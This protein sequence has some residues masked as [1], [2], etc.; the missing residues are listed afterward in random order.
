[1]SWI[2]TTVA[3]G[4]CSTLSS[5]GVTE[6]RCDTFSGTWAETG[7]IKVLTQ[8]TTPAFDS[9]NTYTDGDLTTFSDAVYERVTPE[10]QIGVRLQV[11]QTAWAL[12]GNSRNSQITVN[13]DGVAANKFSD[14]VAS[15]DTS[16]NRI[17][18]WNNFQGA[19]AN[20]VD[21]SG[22]RG[23]TSDAASTKFRQ[24]N[25]NTTN[26]GD[27]TDFWTAVE[28]GINASGMARFAVTANGDNGETWGINVDDTGTDGNDAY[29]DFYW[30]DTTIDMTMTIAVAGSTGIT[31]NATAPTR[32]L[33]DSGNPDVNPFWKLTA[34]SATNDDLGEE[35][36]EYY[37]SLSGITYSSI[38]P[39]HVYTVDADV[40]RVI[41]GRVRTDSRYNVMVEEYGAPSTLSPSATEVQ[42]TA[43]YRIGIK[44]TDDNYTGGIGLIVAGTGNYGGGGHTSQ[45]IGHQL[46]IAGA[47]HIDA[48]I[49]GPFNY[50]M[51]ST[52]SI[53]NN[54]PASIIV[55]DNTLS[56]PLSS[57]ITGGTFNTSGLAQSG[58]AT[59]INNIGGR[60]ILSGDRKN[61]VVALQNESS[62]GL[63]SSSPGTTDENATYITYINSVFDNNTVDAGAY[64]VDFT[65]PAAG[66]ANGT[67]MQNIASGSALNYNGS[68]GATGG[69]QV[70][71]SNVYALGTQKI[72]TSI[73]ALS[74]GSAQ[75]GTL[76]MRD[77][78]RNSNLEVTVAG[79]T[80]KTSLSNFD[81][82]TQFEYRG[83]IL[84]GVIDTWT[85]RNG[86]AAAKL[87][88]D[89]GDHEVVLW[90]YSSATVN[91]VDRPRD[92][93]NTGIWKRDIRGT[94]EDITSAD[95]DTFDFHFWSYENNYLSL[96][97]K[98]VGT[99]DFEFIEA[100]TVDPA[101]TQTRANAVTTEASSI[102][103]GISY[104]GSELT[105]SNGAT[106]DQLYDVVKL[107]K[108]TD[109]ADENIPSL[110]SLIFSSDGN[111]IDFGDLTFSIGSS[112]PGVSAFNTNHTAITHNTTLSLEDWDLTQL[113]LTAPAIT[114][115]GSSITIPAGC[116][117]VGTLT[118]NS[119]FTITV[120]AD[121]DVSGLILAGSGTF[122]SI[123]ALE[124]DYSP[125]TTATIIEAFTH[126]IVIDTSA[127]SSATFYRVLTGSTLATITES[128][129]HNGQLSAF[130]QGASVTTLQS[131]SDLS[132]FPA[133]GTLVFANTAQ[134]PYT[135][136]TDNGDDTYTLNG[137]GAALSQADNATFTVTEDEDVSSTFGSITGAT[138]S[139][140][141]SLDS[142]SIT[143]L[144]LGDDIVVVVT[145]ADG[146][147][148][149]H[150]TTLQ[151]ITDGITINANPAYNS[152]AT[153]TAGDITI[154]VDS[155]NN[156]NDID[157]E[158][159]YCFRIC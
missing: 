149:R 76:L 130:A 59:V 62:I 116:K 93:N 81:D 92:D 13:A 88:K 121:S 142:T 60:A 106:L 49:V 123:G 132:G 35:K 1:M 33:T 131:D 155:P 91:D 30:N 119:A 7:T 12:L 122:T 57:K 75:R 144:S 126:S 107:R 151:E 54:S 152:G 66:S 5:T 73:T 51:I 89:R 44:I 157:S 99:E 120:E 4:T 79:G 138:D 78:N 154:S 32:T 22:M 150:V 110:G 159:W 102:G 111:T 114:V 86:F 82:D 40:V 37:S 158:G 31:I 129:T 135:S 47:V 61:C 26:G 97:R 58:G 148:V 153:S 72:K 25:A 34:L 36:D 156:D 2:Q 39:T 19:G 143:S 134:W 94:T 45:P 112:K 103:S 23:S 117:P 125:S 100:T 95:L 74:D 147:D 145:A 38:G 69:T 29:A 20:G 71:N 24:F 141:I 101:V 77:T 42:S 63:S 64:A 3:I 137:S 10:D 113:T 15:E 109:T 68:I 27:G 14:G 43:D 16:L 140:T 104:T 6:A 146:V 118:K 96:T 48:D 65:S 70:R 139:H 17:Q 83:D 127:V 80:D 52:G 124:E 84:L 46:S 50:N 108:E 105:V 9:G 18:F 87:V 21:R 133:T 53:N 55:N 41:K 115:S 85:P 56:N 128:V 90:I 136:I 8:D 98:I 67:R 11:D 28:S